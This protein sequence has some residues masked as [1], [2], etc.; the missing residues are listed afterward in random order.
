MNLLAEMSWQEVQDYLARDNR[1][2]LPLGSTEEHGPHLG[3]GTDS[4]EAEAIA[5]GAGEATGVIVAPTLNYGMALAQIAFPGTVSLRPT[6]LIAVLEDIFRSLHRHGFRRVLVVNGHGGN[7]ASLTSAAQTVSHDLDGLRVKSF[8]WWTDAESYRVVIEMLGEQAGSHASP[9][10]TAFMLAV[11]PSAVKLSRLDPKGSL[12]RKPFGS[13][14][15][16]SREITTVQTFA[17]KYPDGIMGRDPGYVT[18][19][20]GEALLQ[21]SVEICAR[22]LVDW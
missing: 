14:V 22:E 17:Q 12:A 15:I 16:P 8:E 19:E 11:R 3:L 20:A 9:G 2:I 6:T 1:I 4:I 21:K 5:R 13:P 7:T 18:R 10:E